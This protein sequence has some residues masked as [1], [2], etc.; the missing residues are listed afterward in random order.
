MTTRTSATGKRTER[1]FTLLELLLVVAVL[2]LLAGLA[3]HS[4]RVPQARAAEAQVGRMQTLLLSA[5]ARALESGAPSQVVWGPGA[6]RGADPARSF[7]LPPSVEVAWR[8]SVPTAV[9]ARAIRFFPDG[10]ATPGE[11]DLTVDGASVRLRIDP[12]G[13]LHAIAPR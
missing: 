4:M 13:R 6:A 12:W 10:S 3:A 7:V 8:P 9:G 11:M 1:G 5:R 2:A